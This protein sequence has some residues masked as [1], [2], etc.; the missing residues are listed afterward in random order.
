MYPTIVGVNSR[1]SI[2]LTLGSG[3]QGLLEVYLLD[4][5][6]L[7]TGTMKLTKGALT[8][9][10]SLLSLSKCLSTACK[11]KKLL[12]ELRTSSTRVL[13]GWV[14]SDP[15]KGRVSLCLSVKVQDAKVHPRLASVALFLH[16]V[17]ATFEETHGG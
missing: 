14:V 13:T 5:V 2:G 7:F 12:E 3:E 1:F 6:D 17:E 4:G 8:Q 11:T 10:A 16:A 15:A 9:E